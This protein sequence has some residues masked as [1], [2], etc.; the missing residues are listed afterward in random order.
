MQVE[1]S[2]GTLS[3]KGPTPREQLVG[4][5]TKRILIGFFT[6]LGLK[7]LRCHIGRGAESV[8]ALDAHGCEHG[9]DAKIT[10]Q[11]VPSGIK[12]DVAGLQITMNNIMIM[13]TL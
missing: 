4:N 7:L 3:I 8:R 12:E 1:K 10:E 2:Q 11:C 6:D 5:T 13:S 9:C